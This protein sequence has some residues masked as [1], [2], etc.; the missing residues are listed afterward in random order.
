M[1][2]FVSGDGWSEDGE[3]HEITDWLY[4]FEEN[5][6]R[7]FDDITNQGVLI[8]FEVDGKVVWSNSK[9]LLKAV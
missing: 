7:D 4:W 9:E 2:I 5:S 6:A 8:E 1:R 3:R